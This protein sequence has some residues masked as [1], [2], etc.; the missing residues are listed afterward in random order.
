MYITYLFSDDLAR[1]QNRSTMK[2][3]GSNPKIN[4]RLL[5]FF[6]SLRGC[7][8]EIVPP[9]SERLYRKCQAYNDGN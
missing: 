5:K 3:P 4:G 9:T 7:I 2:E 8:K 1:N 6:S